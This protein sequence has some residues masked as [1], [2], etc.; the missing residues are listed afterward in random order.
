MTSQLDVTLDRPMPQSPDAERAVLGAI[1]I[2]NHCIAR[3]APILQPTMFFKDAHR[4]IYIAMLAMAREQRE[5]EPLTVKEEL[6]QRQMLERAG[7]VA[8]VSALLDMIPD[9]ANVEQYA[10][11]VADRA[12]ARGVIAACNSSM[13]ELLE[14]APVLEVASSLRHVLSLV[15]IADDKRSRGIGDVARDVRERANARKAQGLRAGVLTGYTGLDQTTG[16]YRRGQ[17]SLIAGRTSHGK[18]TLMTNTAIG[19]IETDQSVRA[20]VYSLEMSDESV[21]NSI[22]AKLTQI[23]LPRIADWNELPEQDLDEVLHAD[24]QMMRWNNRLFLND[25]LH[26]IDD[27]CADARRLKEE[28]GLDVVFVDYLQLLSGYDEERVRERQVNRIGKA[29]LNLAKQ[30][31]VA[32]VAPCQV[33]RPGFDRLTLDDLRE[34]KAI[35]HDAFLV[36]MLNRPWQSHKDDEQNMPCDSIVQIEK[37]RGGEPRDIR[38][39]FDGATQTMVELPTVIHTCPTGCRYRRRAAV[40][41][42]EEEEPS[43]LGSPK[44]RR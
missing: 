13:R 15:D 26:D 7:G 34:S 42:R 38:F 14:G 12:R 37:V 2:N 39:H 22:R 1:L 8:Y 29:L 25:Q 5:I 4:V 20:A 11:I 27:V 17:L 9:V 44:R 28:A 41:A 33:T 31:D 24:Q 16:G 6:A 21:V 10:R 3:V 36:L 19:G 43:L 30:L 23:P 32:T 18:S 40:A 35:G